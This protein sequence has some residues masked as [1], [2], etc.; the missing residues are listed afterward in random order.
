MDVLCIQETKFTE[1]KIPANFLKE[2]GF[3]NQYWNC[4]KTKKGYSGTGV[5]S[6]VKPLN[7]TYGFGVKEHDQEGR[8]ITLEF[9]EFYLVNTYV[10]NAGQKLERLSYRTEQW[11]VDL[12]KYLKD[13]DSKKSVIW[14]GDL[15]VA[16]EPIDLANPN[17]NHKTAG[18]TDEE[19]AKF[20]KLLGSGFVDT[21]RKMNPT[22]QEFTFYS[23][24]HDAKKQN[25]G[26]R[27][28]YYIVSEPF[29]ANIKE[30]FV[31]KSA[32]GSDHV[33]LGIVFS[34]ALA[35]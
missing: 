29:Y 8:A 15:N 14:T 27:L 10:P 12:L 30:Y 19:R 17:K 28:D 9:K 33:P 3:T 6:K 20:T 26:W 32:E 31:R 16:H 13:L 24:K 11:D 25:I 5:F 1:E 2:Y 7:V 34:R 18:F 21:F 35:E 4:C 22:K 23:Y